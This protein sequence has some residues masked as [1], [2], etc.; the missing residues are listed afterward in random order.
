[1]FLGFS[2]MVLGFG[3]LGFSLMVLLRFRVECYG[4]KAQG[5]GFSVMV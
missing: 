4:C 1:M 3:G 2:V 5:L